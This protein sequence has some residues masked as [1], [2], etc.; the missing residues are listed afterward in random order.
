MLLISAAYL[1]LDKFVQH[2][3]CCSLSSN[4]PAFEAGMLQLMLQLCSLKAANVAA[5]CSIFSA[6][7][8]ALLFQLSKLES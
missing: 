5:F 4:V 1:L 6:A 7:K 8:A 2:I 3:Y